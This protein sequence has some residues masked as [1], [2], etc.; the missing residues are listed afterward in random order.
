MTL[1]EKD[2]IVSDDKKK[3]PNFCQSV[4][5]LNI[6]ELSSNFNQSGIVVSACPIIDAI[7]KSHKVSR[8][9]GI[10]RLLLCIFPSALCKKK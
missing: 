4:P 10:S 5:N 9:L 2:E 8:T 6:P 3:L 7:L 1:V